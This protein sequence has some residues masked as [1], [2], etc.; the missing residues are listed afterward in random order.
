MTPHPTQHLSALTPLV[1][2][3][4]PSPLVGD[5]AALTAI[6]ALVSTSPTAVASRAICIAAGLRLAALAAQERETLTPAAL[7]EEPIVIDCVHTLAKA[8]S[9][10]HA[11]L[12][13]G[14]NGFFVFSFFFFLGISWSP[15]LPLR[16]SVMTSFTPPQAPLPPP[17]YRLCFP[18][19]ATLLAAP[20]HTPHLDTALDV[21]TQHVSPDLDLPR[22]A[23]LQ[24]LYHVLGVLPSY[25]ERV[26]PL[27]RALCAGCLPEQLPGA[28]VGVL[29]PHPLVRAEAL[30]ALPDVPALAEGLC[31]DD[32]EVVSALW[33]ARHDVQE[34]VAGIVAIFFGLFTSRYWLCIVL[35][36]CVVCVF[37][38]MCS[39]VGILVLSSTWLHV[40]G[41]FVY[42][43]F[44]CFVYGFFVYGLF[45]TYLPMLAHCQFTK[46]LNTPALLYQ[47][48]PL[49]RPGQQRVALGSM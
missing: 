32:V 26:Q 36:A 28:V 21:L 14:C 16:V 9:T 29:A 11:V 44:C 10:V 41:F 30:R 7:S 37:L 40:Y 42:G 27:L 23:A 46:S 6:Q 12:L 5:G 39:C 43:L 35:D 48:S 15:P 20:H 13:L 25:T 34:A 4:L 17:T 24:S 33:V 19:I 49:Y 31:P 45:E 22:E 2:P 3:L 8:A 38:Y 47:R 1:T 18:L